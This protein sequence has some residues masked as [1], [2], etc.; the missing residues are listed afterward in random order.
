M[1]RA[2]RANHH[3]SRF[4]ADPRCWTPVNREL[5]AREVAGAHSRRRPMKSWWQRIGHALGIAGTN[6][7]PFV[8][9]AAFEENLKRQLAMTPQTLAQL[10]K[11][12]VGPSAARRL[13]YFFYS[14][15]NDKASALAA[16]LAARGWTVE[17]RPS[18]GGSKT[19]VITGW[20]SPIVMGN[21]LV[22][23]WTKEMVEQGYKH[24]CEFDGWGTSVGQEA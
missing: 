9:E 15:S 2:S 12:G 14:N 22:L 18:G 3:E 5:C 16:E 6:D 1:W 20:T 21:D 11:H 17:S 24:D 8:T 4:A 10:R 13:E 7:A 19:F 23:R